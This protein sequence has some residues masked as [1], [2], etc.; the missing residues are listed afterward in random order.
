MTNGQINKKRIGYWS[1]KKRSPEDRLKMSLAKKGK[2]MSEEH[3]LKL[4]GRIS[5]FKGTHICFNTGRT[6]FKKGEKH[7]WKPTILKGEKHWNWKGGITKNKEK[8]DDKK[9]LEW[10]ND[11]YKE[12]NWTCFVCKIR[13]KKGNI[14][15]HHI[16]SFSEYPELRY[17]RENGIVLC[18]KCHL[19]VHHYIKQMRKEFGLLQ[20]RK[21]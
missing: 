2:K 13:C 3:K 20:K 19:I 11:V 12:Y 16:N 8:R 15:A 17:N 4:R 10:R 21:T 9:Y 18:R 5:K 7:N 14:I 6:H 1:G